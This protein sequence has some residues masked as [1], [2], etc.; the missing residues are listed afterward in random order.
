MLWGETR[1]V[2][3]S[4]TTS[5]RRESPALVDAAI[6]QNRFAFSPYDAREGLIAAIHAGG[7]PTGVRRT[8][9]AAILMPS[10]E[11]RPHASSPLVAEPPAN[12]DKLVL[13]PWWVT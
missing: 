9:P 5:K 12:S 11:H 3:A 8:H 6:D 13:R 2:I 10:L 7:I 4:A 1:A